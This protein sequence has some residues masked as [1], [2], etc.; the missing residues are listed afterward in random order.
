MQLDSKQINKKGTS[1]AD[2]PFSPLAQPYQRF[3]TKVGLVTM[4]L[5]AMAFAGQ[6]ER[7]SLVAGYNARIIIAPLVYQLSGCDFSAASHDF[8]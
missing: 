5:R 7:S 3:I 6:A 4:S 8:M 2:V 1:I